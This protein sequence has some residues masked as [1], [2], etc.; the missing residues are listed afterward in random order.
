MIKN[1][2][3]ILDVLKPMILYQFGGVYLHKT[4]TMVNSF[5]QLHRVMDSYM[6]FEG[7][8]WPGIA[9]GVIAARP[10]HQAMEEWRDFIL[11]YY[12]Y[13]DDLYG[14]KDIM[15]MP[16]FRQDIIST[17]GPR[18]L[19]FA[20]FN[21]LNKWGN[22]DAIFKVS[23]LSLDMTHGAYQHQTNIGDIIDDNPKEEVL[24]IGG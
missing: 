1:N 16:T 22:N 2:M 5:R 19:T 12:G 18:G 8:T 11:S 3:L 14:T 10:K 4:F 23:M 9:S 21:N 15:P 24:V 17:S 7:H 13:R 20:V 6:G